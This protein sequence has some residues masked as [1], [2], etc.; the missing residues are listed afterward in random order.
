ML[1]DPNVQEDL[2]KTLDELRLPNDGGMIRDVYDS[3][4]YRAIQQKSPGCL[5]YSFS[6]DG[7]PLCKSHPRSMWPLQ[8]HLNELSPAIR[9]NNI[10]LAGLFLT[11]K[12]PNAH[13]MDAYFSTFIKQAINLMEEGVDIT[14]HS[15]GE[16][17]NFKFGCLLG[18]VDSVAR[19]VI[20]NRLQFNGYFGC[21][22][23]Y[24]PGEFINK[25]MRYPLTADDAPRTHAKYLDDVAAA[26]QTGKIIHGVKGPCAF[27]KLEYFDCVWNFP[28]DYMHAVLL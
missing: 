7:A 10:I 15:T 13:F 3:E 21:S 22:W 25:A 24:H 12:E 14:I 2:L 1:N 20:Q 9:F 4:S 28:V 16:K 23:C 27:M 11:N 17:V 5:T 18:A 26:L 19:P 6:A 8:L